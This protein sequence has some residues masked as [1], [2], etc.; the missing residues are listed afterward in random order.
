MS[1]NGLFRRGWLVAAVAALL[2][3]VAA[4]GATAP[5][6]EVVAVRGGAAGLFIAAEIVDEEDDNS[7]PSDPSDEA[8][9]L[10]SGAGATGSDVGTLQVGVEFGPAPT[11]TLPPSGGG[12]FTDSL[13]DVAVPVPPPFE[14]LGDFATVAALEVSTEGALGATGF[15]VAS[16]SALDADLGGLEAELIESACEATAEGVTGSST[17]LELS[18]GGET[19]DVPQDPESNTTLTAADIPNL[20]TGVTVILNEQQLVEDEAGERLVVTALRIVAVEGDQ[21]AQG[22]VYASRSECGVSLAAPVV[23]AA[24]IPARVTFAG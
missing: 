18:L 17:I 2:A 14:E 23:P 20:G 8:S 5:G 10:A 1:W 11:V 13:A 4:P 15:A 3:A 19:V 12:P 24:P 22:E 6:D 7:V 9:P 16:A 21:L